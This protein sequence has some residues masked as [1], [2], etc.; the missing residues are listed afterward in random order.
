MADRKSPFQ[1]F[2]F[3][4]FA[5]FIVV[6]IF[7]FAGFSGLGGSQSIGTVEIWGTVDQDLMDDYLTDLNEADQ[8]AGYI[9]Y[10][11]FPEDEI[12]D[13][14]VE[15]LASGTGPDLILMD[16]SQIL[17]H[18]TKIARMPYDLMSHREFTETYA[19]EGHLFL[20]ESGILGIPFTVD[21]L[22]LYWNRD[23]FSSN[24]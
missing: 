3:G 9:K 13:Q 12:Q 1:M 21:P 11:Y 22:V 24:G 23:I 20:S 17:R 18:W 8:T 15:A 4:I 19:V 5:F 10:T 2:I 14:F 16:Q 7:I 6:A